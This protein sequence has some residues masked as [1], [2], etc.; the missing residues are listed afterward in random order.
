MFF[1]DFFNLVLVFKDI[2]PRF[3]RTWTRGFFSTVRV[4]SFTTCMFF[5][6]FI[7]KIFTVAM[8]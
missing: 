5:K 3:G 8:F 4:A 2:E 6:A 7:Y 1:N